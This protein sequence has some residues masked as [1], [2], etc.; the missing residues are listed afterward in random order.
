MRTG[1]KAGIIGGVAAV[2]TILFVSI[3]I[4]NQNQSSSVIENTGIQPSEGVSVES[5]VSVIASFYP[6]YEFARNVGMERIDVSTLIP[7]GVEPHDWEPTAT[8][9]QRLRSA[10][11]FIYNG[12]GFEP[13][14]DRITSAEF[15]LLIVET[16]RGIELIEVE[17][18]HDEHEHEA[19]D[20][21]I[22]LD[23]I[24]AKQQV[25][26]I[27]EALIKVDPKSTQY[28]EDNAKAYMAKLD[29][30][31]VKIRSEL[32]NCEK[33]TFVS[34]HQAFSY[35]AK[36]YGLH[37]VSLGG[38]SPEAE[39]SPL[40]LKEL[41]EFVRENKIKVI[42]SEELVDPRLAEVL[43]SEVGAKVLLLSPIEGLSSEELGKGVTYL[44][45]MEQNVQNLRVGLQCK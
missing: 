29:A 44:E 22:W 9:L 11:I 25:S 36:R 7:A 43:A 1:Q 10:D 13:W 3:T 5:N 17:G 32:S 40:E 14:I 15:D 37:E 16:A 20:P 42:Y 6:L 38:I 2:A 23:P 28:Y 30:L 8:D 18:E 21:H 4:D 33:D 35:F 39:A 41:V 24:L 34:F 27:K 31:D 12:A 19:I 26:S 45:K